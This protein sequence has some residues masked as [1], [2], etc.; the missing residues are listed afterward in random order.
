VRSSACSVKQLKE[1]QADKKAE[2]GSEEERRETG[3][4]SDVS[5]KNGSE[6]GASVHGTRKGACHLSTNGDGFVP[7]G[8]GGEAWKKKS[9]AE[10]GQEA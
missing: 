4:L 8:N 6:K 3:L 2:T 10:S 1:E 9:M 5:E 7:N